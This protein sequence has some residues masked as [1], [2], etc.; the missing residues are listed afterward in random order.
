MNISGTCT[1]FSPLTQ[2]ITFFCTTIY[3]VVIAITPEVNYNLLTEG[4]SL[5]ILQSVKRVLTKDARISSSHYYAKFKREAL[6]GA[7]FAPNLKIHTAALLVFIVGEI[8]VKW[9]LYA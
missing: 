2:F 6:S 9:T 7:I 1:F 3:F 8:V 4:R 5:Y